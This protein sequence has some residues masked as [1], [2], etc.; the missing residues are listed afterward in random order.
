MQPQLVRLE[1]NPN[2]ARTHSSPPTLAPSEA[3]SSTGSTF[4]VQSDG[5]SI[6]PIY[7][8]GPSPC[9]P[10][11]GYGSGLPTTPPA[12]A[13]LPNLHSSRMSDN[14][15]DIP[16]GQAIPKTD[17]RLALVPLGHLEMLTTRDLFPDTIDVC[18]KLGRVLETVHLS[19]LL[20]APAV[21]EA[22]AAGRWSL[23]LL[24]ELECSEVI[25]AHCNL[26]LPG[27]SDSPASVSQSCSVARECSGMTSAH[28]NLRLPGLSDSPASASP[29]AGTTGPETKLKIKEEI[30]EVSK[31][32]V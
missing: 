14:S 25:C 16:E 11:H 22:A 28:Y 26:Y 29:V 4:K 6:P 20:I 1:A 24:P 18:A 15:E 13:L 12:S 9:R 10:V 31:C 8:A 5:I 23:T 19:S 2:Q 32:E 17:D 3:S 27:S 30:Q 7:H 21:L